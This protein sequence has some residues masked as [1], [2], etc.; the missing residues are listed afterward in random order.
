M[1][2][3]EKRSDPLE[4]DIFS[5]QASDPLV[6]FGVNIGMDGVTALYRDC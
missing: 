2:V 4:L 6:V 5:I 3:I 1:S